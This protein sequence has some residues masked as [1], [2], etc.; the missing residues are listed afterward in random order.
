M[1]SLHFQNEPARHKLLDIVGDLSF[2]WKAYSRPHFGRYDPGHT[3]NVAF[4]KIL[5][6]HLL[7]KSNETVLLSLTYTA[8]AIYGITEISDMLPHQI[9]IST[10]R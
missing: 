2:G 5:K 8:D 6:D 4:A 1:S 9:P 10:R 3:T 7:R